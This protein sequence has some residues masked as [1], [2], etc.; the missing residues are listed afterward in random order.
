MLQSHK[1]LV[2]IKRKVMV[3]LYDH[4]KGLVN[5]KTTTMVHCYIHRVSK[6]FIVRRLST[7]LIQRTSRHCSGMWNGNLIRLI[8][9]MD[10]KSIFWKVS[11]SSVGTVTS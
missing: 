6:F 5:I 10:K 3:L 4:K 9:T 8:I 2:N 1:Y 11:Q 7:Y